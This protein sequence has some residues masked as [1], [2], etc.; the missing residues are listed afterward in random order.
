MNDFFEQYEQLNSDPIFALSGAAKS[1][2]RPDKVDLSIGVYKDETLNSTIFDAVKRAEK[3]L[4]EG[5]KNK[6][7]LPIRGSDDLIQAAAKL[8]FGEYD[9]QKMAGVQ[10]L[11]GTGALRLGADLL[12]IRSNSPAFISKPTWIN[13]LN[14]FKRAGFTVNE[15]PYYDRDRQDY[16]HVGCLKVLDAAPSS[17]VIVLHAC[18]HNPTGVDPSL[19]QWDE[20]AEVCISKGLIPFFDLAYLG[21][22]AGLDEDAKPMRLFAQKGLSFLVACSFSK[23]LSLYGERTGVLLAVSDAALKVQSQL[24]AIIR[25]NYSNPPRHGALLAAKVLTDSELRKAWEQ[26]LVT[27]RKRF[28]DMRM[29]LQSALQERLSDLDLDYLLKR[30]GMFCLL[31]LK[32]E[33]V[34]HLQK[35]HGIYMTKGGRINLTGLN[36]KNMNKVA[37]AIEHVIK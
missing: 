29:G 23:N 12:K 1:D 34:D 8:V 9:P 27:V 22:G 25:A 11:G 26:E 36:S 16:D 21:F 33:N 3:S 15:Y 20:I 6:D 18:C 35:E 31:N 5:Q 19:D 4:L 37:D 7:Y 30:K 10:S 32:P 14:I 24:E 28:Q 17:S 13:H 2:P